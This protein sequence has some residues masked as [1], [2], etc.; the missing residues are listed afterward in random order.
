[1]LRWR[2]IILIVALSGRAAGEDCTGAHTGLRAWLCAANFTVKNL[3]FAEPGLTAQIDALNCGRVWLG[4]VESQATP[5]EG[6]GDDLQVS[7]TNLAFEWCA[8]TAN[9]AP[10]LRRH[11]HRVPRPACTQHSNPLPLDAH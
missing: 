9:A 3:S 8:P 4:T 6:G 11:T 5:R 10:H 7:L 2:V 1:M